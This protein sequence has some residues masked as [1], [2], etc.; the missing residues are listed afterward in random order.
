M[1]DMTLYVKRVNRKWSENKWIWRKNRAIG[2]AFNYINI[3]LSKVDVPLL[4]SNKRK[5]Q[6]INT[7]T[8]IICLFY[9]FYNVI[10]YEVLIHMTHMPSSSHIAVPNK[11]T[12]YSRKNHLKSVV[13]TFEEMY[14]GQ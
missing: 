13:F 5:K 9:S 10:K 3:H 12:Y 6:L 14:I 1:D 11:C 4:L 7:Y 8:N 2:L